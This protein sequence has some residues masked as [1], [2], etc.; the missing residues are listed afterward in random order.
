MRKIR[1]TF[2]CCC[3]ILFATC[4]FGCYS[5]LSSAECLRIHI[6]A[7]S[8]DESDQKIKYEI[9]DLVVEYLTPKIKNS[10]TKE[11]AI[12][13]IIQSQSA[14]NQLIDGYL[15]EKGYN[16]TATLRVA[17]EYF[18]TRVYDG[19]ALDAGYYDAVIIELGKGCGDNWWC[20][21]YPPLCFSGKDDISYKS[22][23]F[24]F[25]NGL[26]NNAKAK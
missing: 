17:N 3:I 20:V 7:N 25:I 19:I 22:K 15:I 8:N 24:E 11:E 21:V 10:A 23:I 14:V 6:R 18:P 9:R 5:T 26:G 4:F 13:A 16:Y 1:I 12:N 2:I